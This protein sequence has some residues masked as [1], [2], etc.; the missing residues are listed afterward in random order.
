LWKNISSIAFSNDCSSVI[1]LIISFI[2]KG[3]KI[4]GQGSL[5]MQ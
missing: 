2:E 3:I 4:Y 1:C 5:Q